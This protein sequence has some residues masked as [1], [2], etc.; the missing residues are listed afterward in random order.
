MEIILIAAMAKN[1][2]IGRDN[3]IPWHIPEELRFFKETTMGYPVIMGRK[4]FESLKK[5][6]PGRQNI[7]ISRNSQ[8]H[9]PGADNASSF[10]A[11]LA[12][13]PKSTKKAFIL[14]GSQ[15]FEIALDKADTLILTILDR[16]VDG[17]CS[18]PEF[19][20][21]LYRETD[22]I[23]YEGGS[24]PFTVHYYSRK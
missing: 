18:F 16:D 1:R 14:G 8:Y 5:P 24:E 17:D 4:T 3:I 20:T 2:I 7:V 22:S 6:L 10:E 19:S 23:R 21:S 15:I 12:L 13:C 9:S 11:A